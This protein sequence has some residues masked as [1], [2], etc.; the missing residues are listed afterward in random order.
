MKKQYWLAEL[1]NINKY[2]WTTEIKLTDGPHDN[3]KGVEKAKEI[4]TGLKFLPQ[5]RKFVMVTIEDVPNKGVKINESAIKT[6]NDSAK[7]LASKK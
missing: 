3:P 7:F 6:L 1:L 2:G 5:E 4:I